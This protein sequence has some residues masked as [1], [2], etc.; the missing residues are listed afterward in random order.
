MLKLP[1]LIIVRGLPGSGK[2]TLAKRLGLPSFEA[3]DYFT[4]PDGVYR[5]DPAKL[6]EAHAQCLANVKASLESGA[7]TVVSNTFTTIKEMQPYLDLGHVVQVIE[8]R[9]AW[10]SIHGVPDA[11]LQKM[12]D[13]WEPYIKSHLIPVV[14]RQP[15]AFA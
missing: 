6:G 12:R 8:C 1:T 9:G 2:S 11:T 5:F 3:D 4:G 13:R 14:G 15:I 7:E 10:R